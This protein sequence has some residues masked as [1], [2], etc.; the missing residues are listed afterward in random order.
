MISVAA[1][2]VAFGIFR[3]SLPSNIGLSTFGTALEQQLFYWMHRLTPF[4]ALWSLAIVAITA[5]D[6]KKGDRREARLAGIAACC[7]ATGAI[8]VATLIFS[9][10]YTAHILEEQQVIRRIFNH[11]T[12]NHPLP[13]F[14]AITLEEIGGAAVLGAWSALAASRRWRTDRTWIDRLGRLIGMFWIAL[15]ATYIY[16]YAG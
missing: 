2:A 3:Y 9:A 1:T 11:S 14:G 7:A 6:R 5:W 16:G 10:F 13:P 12:Q 15:F 4:P 8:A